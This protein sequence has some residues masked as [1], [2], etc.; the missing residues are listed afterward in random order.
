MTSRIL[1][2]TKD[3]K[4]QVDDLEK[5]KVILENSNYPKHLIKKIME[6]T[7]RSKNK[8]E[9]KKKREEMKYQ[10]TLPYANGIEVLRR[11]R[12]QLKIKLFFSYPNKI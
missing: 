4:A 6:E 10:I 9:P 7:I 11:K 5:L 12:E 3:P 2:T 8:T 1:E